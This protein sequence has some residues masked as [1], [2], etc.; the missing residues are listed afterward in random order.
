MGI[1]RGRGAK[2][3]TVGSYCCGPLDIYTYEKIYEVS[4]SNCKMKIGNQGRISALTNVSG[5]LTGS[6]QIFAIP[7]EKTEEA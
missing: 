2:I 1:G 6:S 4:Q 7:M 5:V 3:K